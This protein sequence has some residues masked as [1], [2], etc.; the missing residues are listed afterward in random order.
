[1][2]QIYKIEY[3]ALGKLND[4]VERYNRKSE[5]LGQAPLKFDIKVVTVKSHVDTATGI[6]ADAYERK[7]I[8]VSFEGD[9]AKIS[10]YDFLGALQWVD[11]QNILRSVPGK[12][13]PEA[14]R[15]VRPHC[16]H[17]KRS[18]YRKDTFVLERNGFHTQVGRNCLRDFLG[19]DPSVA[20]A[21]MDMI[22]KCNG[23]EPNSGVKRMVLVEELVTMAA[24]IAN[25]AGFSKESARWAWNYLFPTK[26]HYKAVNDGSMPKIAVGEADHK[27]ADRALSWLEE[28]PSSAFISNL[29]AVSSMKYI[30]V[31]ESTLAAWI[32][33]AYLKDMEQEKLTATKAQIRRDEAIARK[34]RFAQSKHLGA[35][36]SRLEQDMTL[37]MVRSLPGG[38]FGPSFLY[39]FETAEGNLITWITGTNLQVDEG[40]KL[41]AKFT[42]KSHSV[43]EGIMETRVK[44]LSLLDST[45][46][47]EAV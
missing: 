34:E 8:E 11:G 23:E 15:Y 39:K 4:L 28:Q 19:H 46:E 42:V 21:L 20:L 25:Q 36:G 33:G 24:A 30:T 16:E 43:Y 14:F 38:A 6:S 5:K 26:E 1:M 12:E 22:N 2:A 9:P 47:Q 32:V 18:R 37:L 35:I 41:R 45:A 3:W 10:G 17:C 40:S 44:R 31:R 7:H 13:I 29:K 27:L